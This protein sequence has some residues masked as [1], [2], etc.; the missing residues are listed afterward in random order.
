MAKKKQKK[1]YQGIRF[2]AVRIEVTRT[3]T[4]T[5]YA[6]VLV[7]ASILDEPFRMQAC[8]DEALVKALS[9]EDCIDWCGDCDS[10][11]IE[12]IDPLS[13]CYDEA[14]ATPV[15]FPDKDNEWRCIPGSR[16]PKQAEIR[17]DD[18]DNN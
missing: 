17:E 18:D 12:S 7:P 3:T 9:N 4:E 10:L 15:L 5:G 13:S 8:D 2:A 14:E 16:I 1:N 6:D 11:W